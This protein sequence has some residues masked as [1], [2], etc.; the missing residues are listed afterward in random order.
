MY[1]GDRRKETL[2]A[3][4]LG[5]HGAGQSSVAFD[6]FEDRVNQVIYFRLLW[7]LE[8]QQVNR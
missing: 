1:A 8:R 6:E 3:M 7:S 5:Y 2:V 4:G